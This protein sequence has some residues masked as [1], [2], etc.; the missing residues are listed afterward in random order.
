MSASHARSPSDAPQVN[1]D[2]DD[3]I[4]RLEMHM[5]QSSEAMRHQS[6]LMTTLTSVSESIL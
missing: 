5:Q 1:E 6:E 2:M 3:R 4:S